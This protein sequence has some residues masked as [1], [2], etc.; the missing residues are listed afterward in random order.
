MK[1]RNSSKDYRSYKNITDV[2]VLAE[3]FRLEIFC[4]KFSPELKRRQL[5]AFSSAMYLN[6]YKLPSDQQVFF[7]NAFLSQFIAMGGFDYTI[8]PGS[9]ASH[10]KVFQKAVLYRSKIDQEASEYLDGVY[11]LSLEGAGIKNR[12]LIALDRFPLAFST[13]SFNLGEEIVV[14]ILPKTFYSFVRLHTKDSRWIKTLFDL[15]GELNHARLKQDLRSKTSV[16]LE[17]LQT[18]LN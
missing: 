16:Q 4:T 6:L 8:T 3:Y 7:H 11:S 18:Q 5:Q 9:M 15:L 1:N 12:L 14:D 2:E 17:K 13:T 10:F